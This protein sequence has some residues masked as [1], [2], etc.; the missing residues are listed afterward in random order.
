DAVQLRRAGAVQAALGCVHGVE[1]H[2]QGADPGP[3]AEPRIP[4]RPGRPMMSCSYSESQPATAP[5]RLSLS[6]SPTGRLGRRSFLGQ[7][8]PGLAGL[9]AVDF[10]GY[11]FQHGLPYERRAFAMAQDLAAKE[12]PRFLV[13]WF[14]E[15]GWSGYDMFN[16]VVTPN[17]VVERLE[18]P[19]DE[20]YRV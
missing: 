7:A 10:L 16:P 3:G 14:Q 17:N 4:R 8:A 15:G 13:Y 20:R 11:F 2:D 1:L 5:P 18:N 19:S 6:Q 9:S 12:E